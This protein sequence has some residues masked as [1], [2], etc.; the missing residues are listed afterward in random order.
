V[1]SI[2]LAER[3]WPYRREWLRDHDDTGTDIAHALFSG[4]GVT[5]IMRL[6]V[7]AAGVGI[8]AAL[9]TAFG[10]TLWPSAWPIVAQLTLALIVAELPQYWLHRW[11]H[12]REAL[13]R[14]HAVHHSAPRLYW[15][16]AA[17]FHPV[18]IGLL[19]LVGYLP[20]IALG[21][22]PLVIMLFTLFDAVF[23]MLQHANLAM[24]LGPLNWIFSAA[25]PHRWHHSRTLTEANTNYGSN[26]IVWDHV[27]GSFFLPA[28]QQP[29]RDIGLADLPQ[30]PQTWAAQLAA[31]L[32]WRAITAAGRAPSEKDSHGGTETR[33]AG[34]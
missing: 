21:A 11:Q 8:A 15:L 22:P 27:F 9:S 24:R 26:L 16:N 28:V 13:W 31:P 25:E 33:S 2:A 3:R 4:I 12:E 14:F 5:Q 6:I 30:F 7:Q 23:G 32:R 18:D 1:V 17:R 34:G 19:Y 20:L 10:S 29:P